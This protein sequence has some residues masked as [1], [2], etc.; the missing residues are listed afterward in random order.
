MK[1]IFFSPVRRSAVGAPSTSAAPALS[2]RTLSMC[3]TKEARACLSY[4]L[5][6]K[7]AVLPLGLLSLSGR[8]ILSVAHA[9]SATAELLSALR[10]AT[11][12]EIRLERVCGETIERA[13]FLA[14]HRDDE[15]VRAAAARLQSAENNGDVPPQTAEAAGVSDFIPAHGEAAQFLTSLIEHAIS[16]GASDLHITPRLPGAFI[17]VR[18]HGELMA[19]AEPVGNLRHHEQIVQR[20]KVLC[21]LD[22]S[23][24]KLPQDGA[25]SIPLKDA[26]QHVRVSIVPTVHGE[27]AVLRFMGCEGL[28]TLAELGFEPLG[29]SFVEAFLKKGEGLLLCAGPTGSGKSTT[30]Y[31]L[32]HELAQRNLSLVSAEDPVEL[33]VDGV[34]QTALNY[35]AGLDYPS[36]LRSLLR[37]DPDAMLIGE[38]RDS[39]S[40]KIAF[41]AALTG[42]LVISTVH[43]RTVFDVL[44]RAHDLGVDRLSIGQALNLIICQRLLPR[45]CSRCRVVDLQASNEQGSN[46]YQKVGCSACD[47]SGYSGRVLAAEMLYLTD[48]LVQRIGQGSFTRDQLAEALSELC[49]VPLSR[50][51]TRL[52]REGSI[53]REAG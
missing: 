9:G 30:M 11:G 24:H 49:Y 53:G 52:L 5:A 46:V 8:Q 35:K 15:A 36:C 50:G 21:G 32:M 10:F 14:Y 22:T 25:F 41:Q 39:E 17:S 37:Q 19:R 6:L 12:K 4:E 23:Q 40:A 44:L 16:L 27:K 18:V 31:A 26:A 48:E 43:A 1:A 7:Y 51:L 45:L 20:I 42:H 33:V 34:A 2:S 28:L 38:I 13:I 29:F 3:S 47:Y